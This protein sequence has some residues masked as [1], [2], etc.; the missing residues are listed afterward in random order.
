MAL[1]S[2]VVGLAMRAG[3]KLIDKIIDGLKFHA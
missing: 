3:R 1:P 2:R